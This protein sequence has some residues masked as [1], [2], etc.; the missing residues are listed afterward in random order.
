MCVRRCICAFLL[1][2]SLSTTVALAQ[3]RRPVLDL[4]G[5]VSDRYKLGH[6]GLFMPLPLPLSNRD[7]VFADVAGAFADDSIRQGWLGLGWRHR[8]S[9]T[10]V[11]GTYGYFDIGRSRYDHTFTQVSFGAEAVGDWFEARANA[12]VPLRRSADD[13]RFNGAYVAGDALMVRG[14]EERA[15]GGADVEAGLR[16]PFF[17]N[18]MAAQIK[19]MGGAYWYQGRGFEETRGVR[20]RTELALADLPGLAS[21]ATFTAGAGVTYDNVDKAGLE[22]S[23]R[24]RIPLGAS[25][26]R[27]V[28]PFDPMTQPVE[29]TRLIRTRAGAVGPAERAVYADTGRTVGQVVAV[30]PQSGGAE[31]INDDLE[32]AGAD[33][34]AL[35]N[36]EIALANT[37]FLGQGQYFLGGGGSLAV[38]GADSGRSATFRNAGPVTTLTGLDSSLDVVSMADG[39]TISTVAVR[40]GQA[41]ISGDGVSGLTIRNVDVAGTGGNGIRLDDVK[42]AAIERSSIHDLFVCENNTD[43]EFSVFNPNA[44]PYA[45]ISALG[46]SNLTI[47]DTTIDKV[48]YGVFAGSRIDESDWPPVLA[49]P[50][51]HIVLDNVTITN[52]RR[53][54]VLL[55]A[56]RDALLNRVTVDNSAQ[57]LDMDLVVLQGSSDVTIR[58]S[59]F[60]GGINGL[61]LVSASSLPTVT[62]NVLVD[63]LTIE[64]ASNAGIFFNPVSGI[65]LRN[66]TVKDAGRYGAFIYGSDFEFLG[67]PVSDITFE[68]VGVTGAGIA[69]LYFMGPSVDLKGGVNVS[70]APTACTT[71]MGTLTQSPGAV[72]TLNGTVLDDANF[73][74]RCP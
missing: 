28:D 45:A 4:G 23:L 62:T 52:S 64:G 57:G 12:Y 72:F 9:D 2:T 60:K 25:P 74:T 18:E 43:C 63:G 49:S 6:L 59:V 31:A 69:G 48:T 14:G 58:D 50:A 35:A 37:L 11:L 61:M 44:A 71:A 24:L 16:M 30:T 42:G 8:Y 34:L 1:S 70:D 26:E 66:V 29:R 53:E 10:L 39:S 51:E 13:D 68:N 15:Q 55:V 7:L 41:G 56:A 54:G 38:R 21:D 33:A 5:V 20:A 32:A 19:V 40:G 65:S 36:G 17:L 27:R 67:G 22:V 3:D 46:T 47:R 73:E